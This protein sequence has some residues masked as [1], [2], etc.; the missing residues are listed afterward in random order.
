VDKLWHAAALGMMT[1]VEQLL[2]RFPATDREALSQAFWHACSGGQRRAAELLLALGADL[3]WIPDY[4]K[5]TPLEAAT[6][7]STRQQNVITWLRAQ[8]AGSS[9]E[10][11]KS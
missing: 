8:G 11:G 1:R 3:N 4:A 2:A 7:L 9:E 6:A 10:I 5:G